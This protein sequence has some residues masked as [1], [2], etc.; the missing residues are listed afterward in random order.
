MTDDRLQEALD[1]LERVVDPHA[2]AE[3]DP[4]YEDVCRARS[5]LRDVASESGGESA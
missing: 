3:I 1:C 4:N 2:G 5:L